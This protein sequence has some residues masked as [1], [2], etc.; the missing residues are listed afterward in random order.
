MFVIV[1][2]IA[3]GK[4]VIGYKVSNGTTVKDVSIEDVYKE[5][6]KGNL[7]VIKSF[8]KCTGEISLNNINDKLIPEYQN[9]VCVNNSVAIVKLV[10][11]H[12][13]GKSVSGAVVVIDG[14]LKTLSMSNVVELGKEH[15]I[16]NAKVVGNNIVSKFGTFET[17]MKNRK[18]DFVIRGKKLIKYS[19][20]DSKVVI[21]PCIVSIEDKAFLG[22][23]NLISVIIPEG[24]ANIG[25]KAF[26]GCTGLVSVEIPDSVVSIGD[27]AFQ[28]CRNIKSVKLGNG[29]KSI[30]TCTFSNCR[31][32][33]SI[34]I[35]SS[36]TI[37]KLGAFEWCKNLKSANIPDSVE[38]IGAMAFS[39]CT[40]LQS[41][42]IPDSVKNI[43]DWAFFL[44]Q[45]M[46]SIHIGK[47][48]TGINRTIF[49]SDFFKEIDISGDNMYL[50]AKDNVIY[51]KSGTKLIQCP[52]YKTGEFIVPG[53]VT[54]IGYGAFWGCRLTSIRLP[55]CVR[56]IEDM[57]FYNCLKLKS[58]NI[59]DG[60]KGIGDKTFSNCIRLV[61]INIPDSVESIGKQAFFC[62]R[63]VQ[64]MAIPNGVKSIGDEAFGGCKLLKQ[65]TMSRHCFK[66]IDSA[67]IERKYVQI[68]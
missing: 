48:L 5:Y 36:V 57:A 53:G 41:I 68:V 11:I 39:D 7:P 56:S 51:N 2:K 10:N 32:L 26:Y 20:K 34:D 6:R 44:C 49:D 4:Q 59:P 62:C 60:V 55:D 50:M 15:I 25:H 9:G 42:S 28:G 8:D 46:K 52:K 47:G 61:S 1:G 27:R 45:N 58:V 17:Q 43:G 31:S 19:G 29:I 35:P 65:I 37:I 18:S 21:P 66:Y 30:G 33:E 22:C 67:E 16:Y 63:S 38:S 40:S 3:D 54:S 23:T 24:V 64:S 14:E 12:D 13:K